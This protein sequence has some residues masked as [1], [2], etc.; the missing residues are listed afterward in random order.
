M[1]QFHLVSPDSIDL[2]DK[3]WLEQIP[4]VKKADYAKMMA[5]IEAGEW[6]LWRLGSPARGV[7]VTYG[8]QGQLFV[9]YLRGIRLFDTLTK[10]D[11]LALARR[12]GLKGLV[13]E[14]SSIGMLKLLKRLGWIPLEEVNGNWT[15]ELPDGQ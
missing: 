12:L 9:Y 2:T 13:C 1:I 3:D 4:S 8:W 7:G 15:L 5:A 14:T 6:Q 10:E 11:L